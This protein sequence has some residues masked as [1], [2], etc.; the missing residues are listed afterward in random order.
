MRHEGGGETAPP[1]QRSARAHAGKKEAI[2]WR[3]ILVLNWD[4]NEASNH[5][6]VTRIT[7]GLWNNND[8]RQRIS[9]S[10]QNNS[11][12]NWTRSF[13]LPRSMMT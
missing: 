2:Q 5:A 13:A 8:V 6:R 3:A 1:D 4:E 9:Y 12:G 7:Y 10:A 11:S